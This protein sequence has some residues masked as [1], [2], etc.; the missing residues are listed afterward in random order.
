LYYEK[1]RKLEKI[2]ACA[3]ELQVKNLI[4]LVKDDAE[5]EALADMLQE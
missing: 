3:L 4:I 2:K 5:V 1:E